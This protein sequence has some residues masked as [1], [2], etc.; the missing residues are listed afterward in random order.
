MCFTGF[1]NY[2][3]VI[4]AV[5][6]VMLVTPPAFRPLHFKAAVE[7]GKHIFMEKPIAVDPVGAR[8]ILMTAKQA[9]NQGL[10]V[11][12]GNH[13][14][15]SRV[16][17]ESYKQVQSGLIGEI[18]SGNVY[19]N[20]AKLWHKDKNPK[21]TDMEWML[22]DW[23]NWCWLSG[24]HIVEQHVHNI[25]VFNWFSGL[26]PIKCVGFGA[27]HRRPTGNQYDMFNV[28]FLYDG[29]IHLHSMCRQIDGCANK[30]S[31]SI[32]GTKGIC[33]IISHHEGVISDLKGNELWRYNKGKEKEVFQQTDPYKLEHANWI[34][35]IRTNKPINMAEDIAVSTLTA[36]MGRISAYTGAE[37]TWDQIM[38][39]DMDLMP[40]D[41]TFRDLDMKQYTI[42]VPGRAAGG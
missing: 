17:T 31:E 22:R 34:N 32:R 1:D 36:M 35:R 39:M 9:N 28:D 41:L 40:T 21:W 18:V 30:V 23:Y 25:D 13:Q 20:Q 27:R 5:D 6:I 42:P 16:H 10:C 19:W 15:H 12:T 24:D 37:I 33:T 11:V 8:S 3:K 38:A 7:A 26:K 4:D 2:R 29:D 14:R